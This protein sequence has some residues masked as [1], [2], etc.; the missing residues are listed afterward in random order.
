MEFSPNGG[1]LCIRPIACEDLPRMSSCFQSLHEEEQD[2]GCLELSYLLVAQPPQAR[3]ACDV[4]ACSNRQ[5]GPARPAPPA[6]PASDSQTPDT[7]DRRF[8][9]ASRHK[10]SM[11]RPAKRHRLSLAC[12]E[13]RKR[14]AKCD[15]EMPKCRNCRIRGS[16]CETTD[17]KHPELVAVRKYGAHFQGHD[18][19]E[20]I[21][22]NEYEQTPVP[23]PPTP[24]TAERDT[25][26]IARSYRAHQRLDSTSARPLDA[27]PG[28][29]ENPTQHQLLETH[30]SPEIAL[31]TD[32]VSHRQKLMGGNS[33]QSLSISLDL[34]LQ[35]AGLPRIEPCFRHGVSFAEE[36]VPSF[37]LSL[38]ELPPSSLMDRY[39]EAYAHNIH[40]LY[41]VIEVQ[42]LEADV[43]RIRTYQDSSSS[44]SGGF[45]DIRSLLQAPDIPVLACIYGV[46]SLGADETAGALTEVGDSYLSAAYRL[47]AHLIGLPHLSS[48]Q[49]L[50]L[51]TLALQGRGKQGQSFHVLGSAIRISHSIGLHRHMSKQIRRGDGP[52]QITHQQRLELHARIWWT[53]Y[54][55]EKLFELETTRPSAIPHGEHDQFSPQKVL[56]SDSQSRYKYFVHWVSLATL[57]ERISSLLYSRKRSPESTL[58][59]LQ[60][61][62][63]IDQ[64]LR[65]WR[66]AL[67]EDIRSDGE[68]YCDDQERPFAT[69]LTL[70]YHQ[71]LITLHRASLILPHN[72]FLEEIETH[73]SDLPFHTRLRKGA[74]LCAASAVTT[75]RF[76]AHTSDGRIQTSLYT[77]T[78]LLHACIVLALSIVRQPQSPTVRSDLELLVTGTQLAEEEYKRIGQDPN[79]IKT[80]TILRSSLTTYTKQY[81]QLRTTSVN[82]RRDESFLD[83][84]QQAVGMPRETLALTFDSQAPA[85]LN[86]AHLFEGVGLKDHWTR[87]MD[88]ELLPMEVSPGVFIT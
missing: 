74:N 17:L 35:R 18:Y 20:R 77:L 86:F 14:K 43:Q 24:A 59:L 76:A 47:Y 51:I 12:N 55:L 69:F 68:F 25:S 63:S 58:Q 33:L 70:H 87:G 8:D 4:R 29:P 11:E 52:T 78:Q 64:S 37:T 85:D 72:Q 34:H 44:P 42:Q 83:A 9:S 60:N 46:A 57:L 7:D 54:A 40:P 3:Q 22:S 50:I 38:P 81:S 75:I 49:A 82:H 61:I 6:P 45:A 80:C 39:L 79:F 28:F 16:I 88:A 26:W 41:P 23:R 10:A 48:V 31:N 27:S 32:G 84:E 1:I 66:N 36:F 15:T 19:G 30:E 21:S 62:G 53:C 13:C 71:A 73:C 65:D 2:G 5:T 56:S 67:P